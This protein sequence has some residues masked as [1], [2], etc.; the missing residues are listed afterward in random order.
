M[1]AQKRTYILLAAIF[2]LPVLA[3]CCLLAVTAFSGGTAGGTLQS[4]RTVVTQSDSIY[5]SSQFST[6]TATITS[7]QR[8][9]VV[10]PASLIVDGVTIASIDPAVSDV[11]VTVANG[12]VTF[13]ADGQRVP[14]TLR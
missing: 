6:D 14:T 7:G 3:T 11:R 4:G 10:Q 1:A 13:V 12:D 8:T 2:A 9:I 5:L